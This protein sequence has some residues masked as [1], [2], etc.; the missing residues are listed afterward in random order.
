[1]D[2]RPGYLIIRAMESRRGDEFTTHSCR[3]KL[4]LLDDAMTMPADAFRAMLGRF[5][6]D[7][8]FEV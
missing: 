5:L 7:R 3:A 8:K 1:V 2:L 6:R 4:N